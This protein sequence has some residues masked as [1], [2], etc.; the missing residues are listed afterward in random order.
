MLNQEERG[1]VKTPDGQEHTGIISATVREPDRSGAA[2]FAELA[3][4]GIV[5]PDPGI[6][7]IVDEKTGQNFTGTRK[8][9]P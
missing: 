1:T 5:K 4:F 6:I 8:V 3:T 2:M 9:Y 7:T